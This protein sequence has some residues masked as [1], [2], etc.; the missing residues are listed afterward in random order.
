MKGW[1]FFWLLWV[2]AGLMAEGIALAQPPPATLSQQVWWLRESVPGRMLLWAF[3]L[4]AI[5]HW[6][7]EPEPCWRAWFDDAIIVVVAL[8]VAL[9][10]RYQPRRRKRSDP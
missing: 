1:A 6:L 9:A 3:L 7:I 5:W 8:A 2:L 10:T 4:W